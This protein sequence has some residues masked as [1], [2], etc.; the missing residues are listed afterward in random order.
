MFKQLPDICVDS[1]KHEPASSVDVSNID[2]TR[3]KKENSKD[4]EIKTVTQYKRTD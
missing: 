2:A 1:S 3:M 4:K